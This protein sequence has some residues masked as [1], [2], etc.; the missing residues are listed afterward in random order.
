MH[1]LPPTATG[2]WYLLQCKP[3]QDGRALENLQRQHY[4]C[5]QPTHHQERLI[6]GIRKSVEEPLFP[7]YLFICLEDGANWA[8]LRSTRGVA[9]L[10]SFGDHPRPVADNLINR[11]RERAQRMPQPLLEH[12]DTVRISHGPLAELEAIFL[13]MQGERRVILLMDLLQREQ[14]VS[15]PLEVIRKC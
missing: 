1:E 4:L 6:R 11:L 3:R 15:L 12:G 13:C 7:G 9:R 10:V 14:R 2:T 8:P 5:F